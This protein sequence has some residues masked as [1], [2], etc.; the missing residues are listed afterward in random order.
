[1]KKCKR[2]RRFA[3]INKEMKALPLAILEIWSYCEVLSRRS[4]THWSV[5]ARW[6]EMVRLGLSETRAASGAAQA[7]SKQRLQQT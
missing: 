1:M 7:A 4:N 2:R 3:H 5:V 6:H